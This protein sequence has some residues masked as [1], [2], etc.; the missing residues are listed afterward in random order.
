MYVLLMPFLLTTDRDLGGDDLYTCK[1]RLNVQ[2]ISAV[3]LM[4]RIFEVG[5]S[6]MEV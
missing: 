1:D 4:T 3:V 2:R 5:I 6:Q